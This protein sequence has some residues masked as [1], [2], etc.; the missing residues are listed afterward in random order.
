[1][2]YR[3]EEY[4]GFMRQRYPEAYRTCIHYKGTMLRI[5]EHGF[6]HLERLENNNRIEYI[7]QEK[8]RLLLE[9]K[10]EQERLE[11]EKQKKKSFSVRPKKEAKIEIDHR[12]KSNKPETI[13]LTATRSLR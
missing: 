12:D 2:Q 11:A 8:E 4:V 7:R 3:Q 6:M 1:M 9:K 10:K 13:Q 5:D